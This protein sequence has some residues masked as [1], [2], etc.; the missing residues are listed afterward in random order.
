MSV[1]LGVEVLALLFTNYPLCVFG[2]VS[3]LSINF[4][5]YRIGDGR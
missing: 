2:E 5:V 1:E 4:S 3:S